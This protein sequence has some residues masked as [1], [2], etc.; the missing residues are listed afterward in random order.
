MTKNNSGRA[1]I[2]VLWGK[3]WFRTIAI[4]V[5]VLILIR[6]ALPPVVKHYVNKTLAGLNGYYGH[7]DDIDIALIRGAYVLNNIYINAV[8]S[9]GK[10]TPFFNSEVVDLSVEWGALFH[11]K[12]VG[13][14]VFK[15][16]DLSFTKNK[17]EPS[18]VQKDTA[19][20]HRLRKQLM[21]LRMN[22]C[23]V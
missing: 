12:V 13:E 1:R 15:N 8:D 20:F 4:I 6:I 18:D 23:E 14:M 5:V 17:T 19:Q 10:E 21:P 9:A 22:R 7:V 2:K 16:T 3:G 11:G